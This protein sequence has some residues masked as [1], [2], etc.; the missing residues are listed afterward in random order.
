V[1]TR[2]PSFC[3]ALILA[4]VLAT[5]FLYLAPTV[6]CRSAQWG[7]EV[8]LKAAQG[9]YARGEYQNAVERLQAY[10][11]VHPQSYDANELMGLSLVAEGHH[12]EARPFLAAAVQ[13]Q[14]SSS[15]AHANLAANLAQLQQANAAEAEF[16]KAIE[17]EPENPGL[18]HNLGEFYAARGKL[19]EAV[20]YLQKS[21]ELR[22]SYNNGYDLALAEMESGLL[23]DAEKQI[24]AMLAEN[25][26]AELHSLLGET[27]EK[28]HD[29]LQAANEL[30]HATVL[31][32]SESNIFAWGSELLNH[33]T[34][35][36][37]LQVFLKGTQRFPKSW[38]MQLGLGVSQ[39]MLGHN[40]EAADAFCRAIDLNPTDPRPYFFLSKVHSLSKGQAQQVSERFE[41]YVKSAPRDAKAHFYYAM[42]LWDSEN[43]HAEMPNLPKVK[44][45]LERAVALAPKN[46]EMHLQLGILYAKEGNEEAALKQYQ[47]AVDLDPELAVARYR[48]GQ[49][50]IRMGQKQRGQQEL[51]TWNE[52][53]V[54]QDEE[55]ERKQKEMLLFLYGAKN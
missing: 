6:G 43:E 19:K 46:A 40:D 34:I 8:N 24:R 26:T 32:P 17:L 2:A 7:G 31:D 38:K 55:T 10:L 9:A 30:Q 12:R 4:A 50:F 41:R 21:Q 39:Y 3:H 47:R 45:L 54:R 15:L 16:R 11:G 13:L 42:N 35:D 49:L 28:K 36:P 22:P 51:A 23:D 18:N 29:F 20:P 48:L 37:A 1:R 33:R 53:K 27:Y 52:L 14:P 25:D 5:G 44:A